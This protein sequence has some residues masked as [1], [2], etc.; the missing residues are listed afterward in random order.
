MCV[1]IY[2]VWQQHTSH[3][4]CAKVHE[5]IIR[6]VHCFHDYI[7]VMPIFLLLHD[8]STLCDVDHL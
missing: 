3:A 1:Y 4:S 5:L 2:N 7:C 6:M 8:L